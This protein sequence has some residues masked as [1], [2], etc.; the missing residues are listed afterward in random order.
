MWITFGAL[1]AAAFFFMRRATLRA[2][3]AKRA[4]DAQIDALARRI[5]MSA[6]R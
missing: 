6:Q 1:F 2:S 3:E 5:A 4:F